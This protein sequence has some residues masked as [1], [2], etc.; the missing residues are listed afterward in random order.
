MSG[1]AREQVTQLSRKR[2]ERACLLHSATACGLLRAN[3]GDLSA[4]EMR[5]SEQTCPGVNR[6]QLR[7]RA[8]RVQASRRRAGR[9][10]RARDDVQR[11]PRG[12]A[13]VRKAALYSALQLHLQH[14]AGLQHVP[15]HTSQ[16]FLSPAHTASRANQRVPPA[17]PSAPGRN[18]TPEV[19]THLR[20]VSLN[21]PCLNLKQNKT[22]WTFITDGRAFTFAFTK[23]S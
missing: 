13:G 19:L 2:L 16:H 8:V 10:S 1:G 21:Q 15:A 5:W 4:G 17:P 7:G 3:H 11:A 14:R 23:E 20:C 9:Q 6:Q 18:H 12:A 22:A